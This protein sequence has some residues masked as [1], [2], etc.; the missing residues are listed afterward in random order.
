[1]S[2]V[3]FTADTHF[4]HKFMADLRGFGRENLDRHDEVLVEN[5]N[6]VVGP[7]DTVYFLGDF[8]FAKATESPGIFKRLNGRHKHLIRGNHDPH[9]VVNLG[10]SSVNDLLRTSF[11][12]QSIVMCHYPM[13]TW[14]NAHHGA[15]HLHGHS[16][17]N[18]QGPTSTR[19]DVGVD[20]HPQFRPFSLEE[21]VTTLSARKYDYI[22]HHDRSER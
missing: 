13:L 15:W 10:W 17:G 1:M 6:S 21:V 16:H 20:C 12:G 9:H 5:W 8:T 11:D 22:D 3:H 14:Q 7:R 18:L 2:E 19:M 4:R